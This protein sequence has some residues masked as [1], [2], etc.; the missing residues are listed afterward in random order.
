MILVILLSCT[1]FLSLRLKESLAM[2][3][4]VPRFELAADILRDRINKC[5]V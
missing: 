4:K 1:Y 3:N 5:L 2:S